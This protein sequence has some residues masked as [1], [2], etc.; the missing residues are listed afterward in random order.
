[1]E[2]E[3]YAEEGKEGE[4]CRRRVPVQ[5]RQ[6]QEHQQP[7]VEPIRRN[8]NASS[9]SRVIVKLFEGLREEHFRERVLF[10]GTQFSILYTSM[11]SLTDSSY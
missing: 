2:R 8:C 9:A 1:M 5:E 6:V 11:Y 10:I 7:E 4:H 3:G